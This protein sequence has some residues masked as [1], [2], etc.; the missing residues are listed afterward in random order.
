MRRAATCLLDLTVLSKPSE[1]WP[2]STGTKQ[3][4]THDVT[5][6]LHAGLAGSFLKLPHVAA[7]A[8]AL[9]GTAPGSHL[10]IP[11]DST[12]I[13][14]TGATTARAGSGDIGPVPHLQRHL[15]LR[16]G[17]GTEPGGLRRLDVVLAK[18]REDVRPRRATSDR[19]CR[20]EPFGHARGDHSVTIPPSAPWPSRTRPRPG[21]DRHAP[22]YRRA[23]GGEE[24]N[25][26]CPITRA[27]D[28]GFARRR[29]PCW[30]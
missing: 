16:P 13:S 11:W 28:A 24:L 14:R 15:G 1:G 10:R 7:D 5:S 27:I 21:P 3:S 20:P 19:S 4:P 29:P 12:S 26:C 17:G 18:R 6:L 22:R 30:Q 8:E 23:R 25:H 2:M 9:R